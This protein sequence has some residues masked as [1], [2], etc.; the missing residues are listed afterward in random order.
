MRAAAH[1]NVCPDRS[2]YLPMPFIVG[3]PRSGTTL[4][5]MMLDSHPDLAIPPETGFVLSALDL[6][7]RTTSAEFHRLII[8]H[9]KGSPAW[10]D[11]G[12]SPEAFREQLDLIGQFSVATGLRCFYK[13]YSQRFKKSRCGDKTPAYGPY[14]R[15]IERLLPEAHFIHIIRD[16]RDVALSLRD[17]WFSPGRKILPLARIWCH[18]VT[19][20]RSQ[21]KCSKQYM[22]VR[23]EQL[24][25]E[26]EAA[27]RAV[28]RF[29]GLTYDPIM[30]DYHLRA[31]ARL[32]EHQGRSA[33]D[34]SVLVTSAQRLR[35]Q[36]LVMEPPQLSRVYGWK[37][38][39]SDSERAQFDKVARPLLLDL[40]YE[41]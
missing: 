29:I 20:T 30:H 16:G 12:I 25:Q 34:G 32:A 26:P 38:S 5:R 9:P 11:F 31:A 6:P 8:N 35:Q 2:Q 28:C 22:E 17:L 40:G 14:L 24:V 23:Y 19:S 7:P 27:M 13:A 39:M 3:A 4:L 33:A 10:C 21:G 15:A 18:Q 36:R 41:A 37:I 1:A